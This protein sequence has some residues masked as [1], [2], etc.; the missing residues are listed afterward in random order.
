VKK[1]PT[2]FVRDETD[3]RYVTDVVTPDCEWV[4][5]GEGTATVKWDG[6]CTMLDVN[7]AWWARREVKPGKPYPDAFVEEQHD[8]V[9]GKTVGWV[10]M[11]DS[12]FAKVHA[13]ALAHPQGLVPGT[14]ELVG[15]KIN[16]NPEGF[17]AHVLLRHGWAPFSI[18][19]AAQGAPRGY[20]D[21][22]RWLRGYPHEGLVF[23]H[24]DG[25]MAKIKVKDFNY[26]EEGQ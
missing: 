15:P 12:S 11:A 26:V 23:H 19:N 7:G 4:L 24:P 1:I 6:T 17:E 5:A 8:S 3:R 20:A 21:L 14:Y 9:T 18:R 16:G 10:P 25:R 13:E 2:M 22:R